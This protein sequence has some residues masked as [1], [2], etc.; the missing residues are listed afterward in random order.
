MPPISWHDMFADWP[1][2]VDL[3]LHTS[4][5]GL[6][7]TDGLEAVAAHPR[8]QRL[9]I[10]HASLTVAPPQLAALARCGS[11]VQLTLR[12]LVRC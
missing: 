2:L 3:D 7:S 12:T 11:L 8:L 4:N 9:S 6:A 10:S 5:S 1:C